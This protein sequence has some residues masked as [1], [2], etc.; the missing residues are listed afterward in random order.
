MTK[1]KTIGTVVTELNK[2][3]TPEQIPVM[4]KA[5][6][7]KSE[8]MDNLLEAVDRGCKMFPSDFFVEVTTKKERLL[9]RTFRDYFTPVLACPA[10]FWDQT[11]F[12][13]N[14]FEGRIEYIWTLPGMNE[15]FYMIEHAKEIM[16]QP[17][18]TGEKEL[19][20]FVIKAINGTLTKMMM[21]Y[22]NEKPNSPHIV[23]TT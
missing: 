7:M 23:L 18:H 20:G 12:R 19:L 17:T 9:E 15:F 1:K 16:K 4:L 14:R 11:V 10:P 22:N 13:Y 8:Y 6:E 5:A 3:H 2:Q 21:E